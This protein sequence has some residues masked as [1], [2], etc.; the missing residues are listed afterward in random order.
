M[1]FWAAVHQVSAARVALVPWFKW[2]W[3]GLAPLQMGCAALCLCTSVGGADLVPKKPRKAPLK[4]SCHVPLQP[5]NLVATQTWSYI[6][7]LPQNVPKDVL[8]ND[9]KEEKHQ[10]SIRSIR[11]FGTSMISPAMSRPSWS[12]SK[13]SNAAWRGMLRRPPWNLGC[14]FKA[15]I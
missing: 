12:L 15:S 13:W 10:G 11:L 8:K 3:N 1:L 4:A 2:Q 14:G 6:C 9:L 7:S 5:F